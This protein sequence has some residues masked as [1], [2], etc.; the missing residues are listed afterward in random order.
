MRRWI[1]AGVVAIA[2]MLGATAPASAQCGVFKTWALNEVLTSADINQA[3]NRTVTANVA[4]CATGDSPSVGQMR[5]TVDPYP[6]SAESLATTVQGEL[7]RLRFQLNAVTGKSYWYQPIDNS[8]AKDT[9]K[10]W[11]ATFTS[12]AEMPADPSPPGPN[13][14]R[15][16][17]K[18]DGAGVTILAY[19][20]SA[21]IINALQGP[22]TSYG[23][24]VTVNFRASPNPGTPGTK[25]DISAD[26][27]SVAGFIKA[28]FAVTI[29][30]TAT[31]ANALDTGALI[32][33]ERY[34]IWVILNPATNTF[35]GLASLSESAPTMPTGY[36]RKR[37]VGMFMTSGGLFIHGHQRDNFFAYTTPRFVTTMP[38]GVPTQLSLVWVPLSSA[39]AVWIK[40]V[41]SA[42]GGAGNRYSSVHWTSFAAGSGL[43]HVSVATDVLSSAHG[44]FRLPSHGGAGDIAFLE[45]AG[46][47]G[48]DVQIQV[49]GW[50]MAWPE[51]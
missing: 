46:Q 30:A 37:L 21:G 26:R 51:N 17:A 39:R 29:D 43:A 40:L 3:F 8:L 41:H 25:L 35:S 45:H 27:I 14:L 33:Q 10:H 38:V 36:T 23:N 2:A 4:S 7:E 16:Y 1:W 6:G 11:G 18:D 48:S 24:S 50:E 22:S 28:T 12:Y 9:S 20:D 47:A 13:D 32:A 15:L 44:P 34:F 42:A 49:A 19:K 5:V 31:G